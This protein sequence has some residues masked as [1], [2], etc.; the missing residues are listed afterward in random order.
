MWAKKKTIAQNKEP[1]ILYSYRGDNKK[2]MNL[3]IGYNMVLELGGVL[4]GV[5]VNCI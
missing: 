1:T 3:N 4:H 2:L 5:V